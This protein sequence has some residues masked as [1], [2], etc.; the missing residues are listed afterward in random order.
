[1]N[2][3]TGTPGVVEINES[4]YRSEPWKSSLHWIALLGLWVLALL[5]LTARAQSVMINEFMASNQ[6]GL[7]D[8][9]GDGSDWIELRNASAAAVNLVGWT[10]TD[11]ATSPAMWAFP[12]VSLPAN[13]YLVV[14][15]SGK[16]RAVVGREL[17]TNFK[18]AS[19]GE[20]LG[21]F[22]PGSAVSASEFSPV[23]PPQVTDVSYGL[24]TVGQTLSL[25]ALN[26]SCQYLVPAN[27]ALGTTWTD[28]DFTPVGWITGPSGIGFQMTSSGFSGLIKSTPTM[29]GVN[30]SCLMR[31]PFTVDDPGQLTNLRLRLHYDDGFAM[32]LNGILVASRNA[33]ATM[34]WN[35]TATASN[36]NAS[37]VEGETFNLSAVQG[38]LKRGTNVLAIQGMNQSSGSFDFLTTPVLDATQ[39]TG[40][41]DRAVYFTQLTPGQPNA[42]GSAEPGPILSDVGHASAVLTDNEDLLVTARA[43]QVSSPVAT[44]SLKYRVMFGAEVTVSMLDDGGHGDGVS[45]DGVY[46]AVIPAS[47]SLPGQM[48]RYFVTSADTQGRTFRWPMYQHRLASPQYLGTVV[49]NPALTSALPVFHWFVQNPSLAETE[50]GTRCSVFYRDEFYDNVLVRIRG[51]SSRS[52]AKKS[53]KFDFNPG[54]HF[55]YDPNERRV[56]EINVNTTFTDKSFIRTQLAYETIQKSG[57]PGCVAFNMRIQQNNAFFSVAIFSEQVDEQFLARQGLDPNGALYKPDLP[58]GV[59]RS[60]ASTT[61]QASGWVK[62]NRPDENFSDIQA[63]E[64]GLRLTNINDR[65]RFLFDNVNLPA[66]VNY[67]AANIIVQGIDRIVSNFYAYRDSDGTGE[68]NMLTWDVD[69]TYGPV[70]LNTDIISGKSDG[71]PHHLSHPLWGSQQFPYNNTVYNRFLD[72][73]LNTP[74]T[75]QM[76]LRRLRSQM[77]QFLNPAQP[78]LTQ[79][80]DQLL[81]PIGPD[82]ILD[83]NRWRTQ[84]HFNWSGPTAYTPS[85]SVERIKNEYLV[86]RRTHLFT[87]HA[88]NST[89]IPT[90]QPVGASIRFAALEETPI[91]GNQDEEFIELHNDNAFAV[92]VSGWTLSGQV[93]HTFAAGT[94]IPAGTSLYL[95]PNVRA[96]RARAIDPRGRQS[97]FIQ[98]NYRGQLSARGGNLELHDTG[99]RSAGALTY[100]GTPSPAQQFLRVTKI[101]YHDA[102]AGDEEYIELKNTGPGPLALTGIRF[103]QGILFNFT[104]S[105][106]TQLAPGA[107]VLLVRNA[108]A[109]ATRYGGGFN[110]GGQFDGQLDNAGENLRLE[111]SRGEA[112]LDFHYNNTWYPLTDGVGFSL[113]IRNEA[114]PENSWNDRSAWRAS[115][116]P[117]GTP[118][119]SDPVPGILPPVVINEV[120]S[121]SVSPALD[122]VELHNPTADDVNISGWYLSDDLGTPRKFRIPDNTILPSCGYIVFTEADFNPIPAQPTGFAFSADGD[123]V[124][125]FSGDAAGNLT[126]YVHDYSFGS[127]VAGVSFG[128]HLT[129]MGEERFV[130]QSALTLGFRN[131]GP[132]V[133]PVVISE[134]MYHPLNTGSLGSS[135]DEFIELRNI[136]SGPVPLF[137]RLQPADT[138]RVRGGVDF[139]FPANITLTAGQAVLL[140]GFDP[141]DAVAS[142][143]FR[144]RYGLSAD[145]LLFGPYLGRLDNSRGRITLAETVAAL[146]GDRLFV[147]VDEVNYTDATPWPASA[148]GS[149]RSIQRKDVADYSDDPSNWG[150]AAP[151]PSEAWTPPSPPAVNATLQFVSVSPEGVNFAATG[152]AGKIYALDYSTS[153]SVGAWIQVEGTVL[154]S[155]TGTASPVDTIPSHRAPGRGFWRLRDPVLQTA[156]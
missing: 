144:S 147:M 126:G 75:R 69:L 95:S 97:L 146:V 11:T 105:A 104:S 39:I 71:A 3:D 64:D 78:A 53:F 98:G 9:D 17:H 83:H 40:A 36:P 54:A 145:V 88:N 139:D 92:D 122:A 81:A 93:A 107:T 123:E 49:R 125:L 99:G 149:G 148:D 103:T 120:L 1:M 12:A 89:G 142:A 37:A 96:F 137:D 15:A 111:D 5:P 7:D 153:L 4:C 117:G 62:K 133:G 55:S 129:G 114:A 2:R 127:A 50:A 65:T 90:A 72:A 151:T 70:D 16:N 84:S 63:L 118:G 66:Q 110:I 13:G 134:I 102:G 48:V 115:S 135:N 32:W 101:M 61:A 10:L 108:A 26:A 87:T 34:N 113:V 42:I 141:T 27:G 47:A 46:G 20:Y 76:F 152:T 119:E 58:Y 131:A 23:F 74:A 121:H 94:V 156:P 60:A 150:A 154:M 106:V 22:P 56:E 25:L 8:E 45:G 68:W 51:A 85:Q 143:A 30:A 116:S 100:S 57:S 21:L 136:S 73:I 79:R 31:F 29:Y 91:S 128:R 59:F 18:L 138:W 109:F 130:L 28:P 155:G 86:Q 38:Q 35:S 44:V 82:V 24:E 67:M 124:F 14:F 80:M 19:G 33:P 112:I 140:V 132:K 52:Y 6:T 43:T 77:D 41:S